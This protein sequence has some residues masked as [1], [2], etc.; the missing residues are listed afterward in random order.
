MCY[1]FWSVWWRRR[2]WYKVEE[3]LLLFWCRL[4]IIKLKYTL[5]ISNIHCL[6]KYI[7][8]RYSDRVV[9]RWEYVFGLHLLLEQDLLFIGGNS[10]RFLF[11]ERWRYFI[12]RLNELNYKLIINDALQKFF[13]S[14]IK[15]LFH[16]SLNIIDFRHEIIVPKF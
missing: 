12:S 6:S 10:R 5:W 14:F 2:R 13:A 11:F 15:L 8:T 16:L 1:L 9:T 7:L 4:L 3:L